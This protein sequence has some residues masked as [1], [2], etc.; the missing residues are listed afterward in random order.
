MS[1]IVADDLKHIS[2][3][4]LNEWG[5]FDKFKHQ[6]GIGTWK[7]TMQWHV[8]RM[9]Q[10]QSAGSISY[11]ISY[12]DGVP[13]ELRLDYSVTNQNISRN[14]PITLESVPCNYGGNR[15]Y[16]I[17]PM[18]KASNYCGKRVAKLYLYDTWFACRH[19]LDLTYEVNNEPKSYRYLSM[20]FGSDQQRKYEEHLQ[21]TG[22]YY[23]AGQPTKTYKRLLDKTAPQDNLS[24]EA[25][26]NLEQSLME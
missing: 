15:W 3:Y 12:T 2:T 7:G 13:Q 17:C 19:C 26:I 14:Y 11:Y 21:K 8:T 9:G 1:R 20:I 23:Y 25:L 16:F 6:Q 22:R 10:R 24:I 18:T 5:I 4:K